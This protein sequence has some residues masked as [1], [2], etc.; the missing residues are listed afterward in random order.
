LAKKLIYIVLASTGKLSLREF[1]DL[2]N[3]K[4]NILNAI[5]FKD[6]LSPVSR[7]IFGAILV[8]FGTSAGILQLAGAAYYMLIS[9]RLISLQAAFDFICFIRATN[10][11]NLFVIREDIYT[12]S[13]NHSGVLRVVPVY[14][15]VNMEIYFCK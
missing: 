14:F 12:L 1:G 3:S 15:L 5:E 10:P 11:Y 8:Q 2:P 13:K 9:S 7:R 6:A 4:Q